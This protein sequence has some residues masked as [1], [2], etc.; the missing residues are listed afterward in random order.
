MSE[1]RSHRDLIVS[2]KAMDL[3]VEIDRLS[4]L[5]SKSETYPVTC[6]LHAADNETFC[7]EKAVAG[8]RA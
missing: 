6:I 8:G 5:F 4:A 2:R 3:A 1:I 7:H